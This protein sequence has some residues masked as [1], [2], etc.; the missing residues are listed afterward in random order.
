MTSSAPLTRMNRNVNGGGGSDVTTSCEQP[1]VV[2]VHGEFAESATWTGV[3]RRLAERGLPTVAFA[4]PLRGVAEDAAKLSALIATLDR[5]VILVGHCY[6]GM[7]TTAAA[8]TNPA[9]RA[10]VYVSAFA[11]A[12]GESAALLASKF[13]G[14]TLS[15]AMVSRGGTDLV[16]D[17]AKF[18]DQYASDLDQEQA[19]L[20]AANQRP[21]AEQA[22]D[23]ALDADEAAWQWLPCWFIWGGAGRNIPAEALRFMAERAGGRDCW[24]IPNASHAL[25]TTRPTAVTET[26]LE[27]VAYL[28]A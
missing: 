3:I 1:V 9:V 14:G 16:I 4:N 26:I 13:E 24:E 12:P 19:A 7:V 20:L 28:E 23:E 27:A 2:L 11:P 21:I 25:T 8:T 6:G 15:D 17:P 10:L 22:M 18:R 5:P